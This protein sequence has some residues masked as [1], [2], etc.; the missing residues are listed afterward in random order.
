MNDKVIALDNNP[1]PEQTAYDTV[2]SALLNYSVPELNK[3]FVEVLAHKRRNIKSKL[4]VGTKVYVLDKF[5]GND[6]KEMYRIPGTIE[7]INIKRCLVR[8]G[9]QHDNKQ[10]YDVPLTNIEIAD[11]HEFYPHA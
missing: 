6:G 4:K 9:G 2:F 10:V 3:M 11:D 5:Q 1:Q 7:R 8:L